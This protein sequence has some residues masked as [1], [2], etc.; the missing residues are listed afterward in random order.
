MF[1][2]RK[3]WRLTGNGKTCYFPEE[4]AGVEVGRQW[5]INHEKGQ[6]AVYGQKVCNTNYEK[7]GVV[8]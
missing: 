6:G 4:G 1:S 3:C 8:S 5:K 7:H 2:E